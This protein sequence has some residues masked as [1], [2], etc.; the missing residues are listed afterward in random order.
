MIR[1]INKK[2]YKVHYYWKNGSSL[3]LSEIQGS[4][5]ET[6]KTNFFCN[7]NI[8]LNPSHQ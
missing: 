2:S 8:Q 7:F 5:Y 4:F 1:N 3:N 6:P